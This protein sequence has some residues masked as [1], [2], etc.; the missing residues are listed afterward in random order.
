VGDKSGQ[1]EL[2]LVTQSAISELLLLP[3]NQE[4]I[5]DDELENYFNSLSMEHKLNFLT[6]LLFG[7]S[8]PNLFFL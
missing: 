3:K 2:F 4:R 5:D 8:M 6:T 7:T 1:H